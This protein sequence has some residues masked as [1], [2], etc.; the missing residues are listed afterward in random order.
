MTD[1]QLVPVDAVNVVEYDVLVVE[2]GE[3]IRVRGMQVGRWAVSGGWP[4]SGHGALLSNGAVHQMHGDVWWVAH[5]LSGRILIVSDAPDARDKCVAI[6]DVFST[7]GEDI[8]SED[9]EEVDRLVLPSE[10]WKWL[11]HCMKVRR[12]FDFREWKRGLP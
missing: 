7:Y 10:V 8:G 11:M 6:A 3:R 12:L 4:L 2:K 1:R 9:C 5:V